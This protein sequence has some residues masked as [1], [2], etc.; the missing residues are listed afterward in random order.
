MKSE[1][2]MSEHSLV[3]GDFLIDGFDDNGE[4]V[5]MLETVVFVFHLSL[6]ECE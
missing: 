1:I 2:Q 4:Q 3:V 6:D 5:R